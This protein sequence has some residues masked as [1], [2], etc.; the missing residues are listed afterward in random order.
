[1]LN[2]R[3]A[4]AARKAFAQII[5]DARRY[6][7]RAELQGVSVQ[8]MIRGAHEVIVGMAH[9]PDF[10]PGIVLGWGGIFVE[11]L[12]DTVWRMPPLMAADARAM[13]DALKGVAI[14]KGARGAKPADLAALVKTLTAFSQLCEDLSADVRE[15]D[16]NPVVVLPQGEGVRALDCLILRVKGE[17]A[18]LKLDDVV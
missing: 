12:Q 3:N 15:I 13:I 10:G 11:V 9:D 1:M 7:P 16:I 17:A 18:A 4:T 8:Q 6:D 5:A 2:I 14:L